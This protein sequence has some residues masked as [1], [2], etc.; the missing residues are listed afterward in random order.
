M[1]IL[2]ILM[3]TIIVNTF[4]INTLIFKTKG[5][6]YSANRF[7]VIQLANTFLIN[8]FMVM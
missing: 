8:I 2:P 3:V 6:L 7:M 1:V 4:V 5:S